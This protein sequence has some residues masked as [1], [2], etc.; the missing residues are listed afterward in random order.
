MGSGRSEEEQE[1]VEVHVERVL[2][3][4]AVSAVAE[5]QLN[6]VESIER[7]K[8]RVGLYLCLAVIILI[9]IESVMMLTHFFVDIHSLKSLLA[10]DSIQLY[11]EARRA[12]VEGILKIGNLFLGSILLPILTLLLG[13][14]FG[15][16][17]GREET[18][19]EG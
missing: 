13:Y 3:S 17:V 19:G 7:M 8:A 10:G 12:A 1:P 18:E 16:Q 2:P 6:P 4:E 14:L 11:S 15:S 5:V 9:G